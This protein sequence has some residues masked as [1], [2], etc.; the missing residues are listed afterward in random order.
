MDSNLYALEIVVRAR[1]ADAQARAHRQSLA[2]LARRRRHRLR[3]WL[4]HRLIAVGR[5][6]AAT[7]AL[8]PAWPS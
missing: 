3:T 2:A 5:R 4:G 7:P 1:L 6:L 8:A